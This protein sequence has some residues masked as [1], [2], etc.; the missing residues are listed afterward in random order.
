M[1]SCRSHRY[2]C[3]KNPTGIKTRLSNL[4]FSISE[5]LD[6][7]EHPGSYGSWYFQDVTYLGT[8][9]FRINLTSVILR[10]PSFSILQ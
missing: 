9:Q 7:L 5:P 8:D 6:Q 1:Y 4:H 2:L 10:E 3:V